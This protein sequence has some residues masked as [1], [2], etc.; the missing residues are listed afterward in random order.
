MNRPHIVLITA[1]ELRKDGLSCYGNEAIRTPNLDRLA[2][3]SLM[4]ERAYTNSP[5]CLPSRCAIATGRLPHNNGAY[6]NFRECRMGQ[7]VP[8]LFSELKRGG[9]RTSVFGKCHFIPVKY[10]E[11]RKDKTLPYDDYRDYY[12]SL[13]IDDLCLQDGKLVS[14]WHYDDYSKE[15]EAHGHLQAY[16]DAA[17]NKETQKVYPS[18][19][20]KEWHPD[21]WVGRKA[22]EYIAS[23]DG[24]EPL[25]TWVSFSGPHYPFDAPADYYD[26]VDMSRAQPRHVKQ[27][28][29][30]P[31]SR[32]HHTSY[33]GPGRIDGSAAAPDR[34]CKNFSDEYWDTLT[35]N[36]FANIVQ[37]D[38][39]IGCILDAVKARFGDNVL[40][41]FTADHGEMLGHHGIWGKNNCAYEDVWNVPLLVQ[42][43]G[44]KEHVRLDEKVMLVDIMPTCLKAAQLPPVVSD[45]DDFKHIAAQGGHP[46]VI[47][48]GEGFAAIS[49]GETKYIQVNKPDE[50]FAELVHL[51]QDPYEFD[52]AVE[53][54]EHAA[55]LFRLQRKLAEVFMQNILA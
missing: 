28:E 9:Y 25:F 4:F 10:A 16:R 38:E 12:M 55:R 50:N 8:T 23:Y 6:S 42:Y 43:P 13:G 17:W 26:K 1:D 52:N 37:I 21:S 20:P 40:I 53:A 47:C 27:G 19:L 36:Y 29:F 18:P 39:Y 24:Q 46:Y 7:E 31:E 14:A 35:R 5:W 2:G 41:I 11:T 45:G 51:P 32:I 34:A 15:L 49:D 33:H 54:P 3:E 22:A 30:D 44:E 48:E